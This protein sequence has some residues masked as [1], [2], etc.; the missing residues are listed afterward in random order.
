MTTP[1]ELT[2]TDFVART[3]RGELWQLLD[4]RED[5]ERAIASVDGSIHIAMAEIPG[6]MSELRKDLP[7][8][9]MCHSGVRSARVAAFLAGQDF[10]KVANLTGG[11]DAWSVEVDAD[12]PRY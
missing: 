11:I 8:A 7:V 12:V 10:P 9:V 4:V 1:P 3:G 5:W 6:R 2:P